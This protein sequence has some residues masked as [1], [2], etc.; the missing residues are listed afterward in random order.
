LERQVSGALLPYFLKM[1]RIGS[2]DLTRDAMAQQ[3]VLLNRE[4]LK[5]Y[6]KF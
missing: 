2:D 1:M 5:A 3:I 4:D 6:L